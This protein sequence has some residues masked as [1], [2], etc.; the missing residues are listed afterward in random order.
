MGDVTWPDGSTAQMTIPVTIGGHPYVVET[1]EGA[2][3]GARIIDV[4]DETKPRVVAKL[5]LE[6][7]M[8]ANGSRAAETGTSGFGYNTHYCGVPQRTDPGIALDVVAGTARPVAAAPVLSTSFGFGGHNAALV[9][10]GVS[11]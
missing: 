8:P 10:A 9:I 11:G 7:Q 6:I 3:G 2:N 5:K 4:A 1:D